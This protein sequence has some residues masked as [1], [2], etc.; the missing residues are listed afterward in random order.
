[1]TH[2]VSSGFARSVRLCQVWLCIIWCQFRTG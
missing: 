2:Q 1:M